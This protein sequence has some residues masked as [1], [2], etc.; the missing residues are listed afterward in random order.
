MKLKITQFVTLFLLLLITGL[1]WGTWF[2]LSRS[3]NEFSVAEFIHIGKVIIANVGTPMAII[4]PLGIVFML[5]SMWFSPEK[6]SG[7]FY[8]EAGAFILIILTLLITV[9]VE[10]P[11]D[12]RIRQWTASTA[13]PDWGSIRER[14]EFF[15]GLRT[16]TSL[17]SFV[18]FSLA[19]FKSSRL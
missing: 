3:I 5:L 1:F 14:W 13:P 9:G 18:L 10:V 15:H 16:F 17:A 8:L 19:I 11:I 7:Y 4:M 2:A 6:K 12:N